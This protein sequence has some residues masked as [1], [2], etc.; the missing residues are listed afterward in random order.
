MGESLVYCTEGTPNF[1]KTCSPRSQ[2]E[3][4][5]TPWLG[6]VSG[7]RPVTDN[8]WRCLGHTVVRESPRYFTDIFM[9]GYAPHMHPNSNLRPSYPSLYWKNRGQS[10]HP[11]GARC[12]DILGIFARN[13]ESP[14]VDKREPGQES[15]VSGD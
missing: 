5:S 3:S 13:R 8:P 15:T 6:V 4:P 1:S 12:K 9:L 11:M 7:G 14:I 10:L 2:C